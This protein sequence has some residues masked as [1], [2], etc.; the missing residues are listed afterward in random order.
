MEVM[1]VLEGGAPQTFLVGGF[2]LEVQH[3]VLERA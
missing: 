2:K 1:A 3:P